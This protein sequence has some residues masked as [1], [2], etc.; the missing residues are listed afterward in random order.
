MRGCVT[1]GGDNTVK[2]WQFELIVDEKSESKAKVLS[3]LHT[4]TL[5][6]EDSVLCVKLSPDN[7]F[8]AVALLDSTV[9]IFFTDT[10]K[11]Y[12]S[13]YGHKLPVLTMDI[14][15]D[16]TLIATGSAD[17]NMKIWGLDF[18]DC[19][20]SLFAHDD[21]VT[22][23][24][25]VPNTHYIFTSGKDGKIK[26]WD[27]D[28]FL[29][30]ITLQG[31][32]G[33]CWSLDVSPNGHYII[34]SGSDRVLRLFEK[35][36]QVV[37]LQ[38]EEEDE[39]EQEES[40]VTGEQTVAPGLPGLNLP[41]KKT[42]GSEKG[43]ESILECLEICEKYKELLAEHA[44]LQA[45]SSQSLPLPQPPPL[46]QALN[47]ST[48]NDFLLETVR[49]IRSSDLEEALLLLPFPSVCEILLSLPALVMRGDQTELVCKLL[50]FLLRIHHASIVAN[51]SLLSVLKQLQKC[52]MVKIEEQRDL[53]GYNYYGMQ[54][55]QREIEAAEGIQ[56]FRDA[57]IERRKGEKKRR[58]REK[59][60]RS[61]MVLNT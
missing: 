45:A 20:K 48:P 39:R 1:G 34:S 5:K 44:S 8:V 32:I 17:R 6:L 18:G 54:F 3:L 7:R 9:K 35:S 49:R 53:V 12:L 23:V 60:K 56:L 16:S 59:I 33:E 55:L 57:T 37:V 13:L 2:F 38:D 28:S 24:K 40:L 10:F 31:H 42:I 61:I 51:N 46:M 19:H 50:M 36:E 11:F 27:A 22:S 14:S 52:A 25:F 30:I 58:N 47:V 41:S 15:S 26:Q 4:R 21:S 43:A 29:K